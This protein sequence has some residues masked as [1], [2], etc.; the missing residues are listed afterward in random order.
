M[1]IYFEQYIEVL[2][3]KGSLFCSVFFFF[4]SDL[5]IKIREIFDFKIFGWD[6]GVY[7]IVEGIIVIIYC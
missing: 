4:F 7:Y 1:I 5:S 6:S 3:K 2:S